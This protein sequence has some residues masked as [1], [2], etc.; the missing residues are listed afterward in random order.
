MIGVDILETSRMQKFANDKNLLQSVFFENEIKYFEKFK[1]P[2]ER[3][4]GCFCAKEA[5]LKALNCP[6][7]VSVKDIEILHEENG[8][9]YAKLHGK[10]KLQEGKEMSISISHSLTVAIAV[11]QII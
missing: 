6:D 7:G 4:A 3:I 11:C 9:P 10:A 2:L 8:R 5:V 1:N